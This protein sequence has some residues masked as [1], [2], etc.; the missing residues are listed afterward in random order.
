VSASVVY[1]ADLG[2]NT[3]SGRLIC[4]FI[5]RA[6]YDQT[7]ATRLGGVI[8]VVQLLNF[9]NI[10]VVPLNKDNLAVEV[11]YKPSDNTVLRYADTQIQNSLDNAMS[12]NY[13]PGTFVG[14]VDGAA[15]TEGCLSAYFC[16]NYEGILKRSAVFSADCAFHSPADL[17]GLSE[18]MRALSSY[19][20]CRVIKLDKFQAPNSSGSTSQHSKDVWDGKTLWERALD[21]IPGMLSSA[22]YALGKDRGYVED[23]AD[24]ALAENVE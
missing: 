24:M 14:Y 19:P 13:F 21:G 23:L 2:L 15:G 6:I 10:L 17:S 18:A 12:P 4:G 16:G 8:S 7:I 22:K 5:P 20:T 9:P 1:K 3:N 11:L